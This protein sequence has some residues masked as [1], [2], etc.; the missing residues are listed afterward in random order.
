[1]KESFILTQTDTH[2]KFILLAKKKFCFVNMLS[3][4]I[5]FI[6]RFKVQLK[7]SL[8]LTPVV[9]SKLKTETMIL[10]KNSK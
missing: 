8:T 6:F 10:N 7:Y 2:M 9:L 5:P 1:M 4:T 3:F